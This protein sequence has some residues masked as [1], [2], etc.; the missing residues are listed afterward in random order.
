[1]YDD[2]C[3]TLVRLSVSSPTHEPAQQLTLALPLQRERAHSKRARVPCAR[4]CASAC[5]MSAARRNV[6]I[7]KHAGNG[8]EQETKASRRWKRCRSSAMARQKQYKHTSVGDRT[9]ARARVRA[10]TIKPGRTALT[11]MLCLASSLA[12]ALVIPT[13]P[14][15]DAA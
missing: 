10:L 5:A 2:Q 6:I 1:M 13:K 14:A 12:A 15:F 8:G 3:V 4:T 7:R 11:L 9:C